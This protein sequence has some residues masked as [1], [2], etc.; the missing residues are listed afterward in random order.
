MAFFFRAEDAIRDIGVPGDVCSSDLSPSQMALAWLLAQGEDI[1][2]I[3][4]TRKEAN[5]RD[6]LG[7]LNVALTAED[8][9]MLDAVFAAGQVRSEERG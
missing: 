6:N 1:I 9:A 3:P 5:L 7:A 8:L 2:P 4:G